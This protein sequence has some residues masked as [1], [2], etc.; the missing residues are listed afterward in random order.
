MRAFGAPEFVEFTQMEGM[1]DGQRARFLEQYG[2]VRKDESTALLL[3]FFLGGFG[4]H[5]F[6]AKQFWWGVLYLAF[7]WTAIRW[8]IAIIECFFLGGW[9]REY[10]SKQATLIASQI[11][12]EC[13]AIVTSE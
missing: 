3:A 13:A 12:Q 9:I 7:C 2:K 5:Q 6:Y 8:A 11:R 10:N 1:N 4:A